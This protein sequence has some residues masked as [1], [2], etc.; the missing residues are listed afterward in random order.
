MRARTSART[1][2]LFALTRQINR[3]ISRAER[4]HFSLFSVIRELGQK[5]AGGL[6][7]GSFTRD[8]YVLTPVT[9]EFQSARGPRVEQDLED[10]IYKKHD[11]VI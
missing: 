3:Q 4:R 7:P 2:C 8:V 9:D 11:S 5:A 10:S 1:S 6:G